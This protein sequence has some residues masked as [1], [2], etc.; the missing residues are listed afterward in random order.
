MMVIASP[1]EEGVAIHAP[2]DRL[3]ALSLSKRLDCFV[4]VLL[5]MTGFCPWVGFHASRAAVSNIS[6]GQDA[7]VGSLSGFIRVIRG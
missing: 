2:L 1:P 4:A 5:A 3:G 7:R 6:E